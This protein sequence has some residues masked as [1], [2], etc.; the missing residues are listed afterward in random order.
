MS[1]TRPPTVAFQGE[2]G[3]FSDDAAEKLL[4]EATT[5]GFETFDEA[6]AAAAEG[7][8]DFALLPVENSITGAIP[9]TY[10]LLW[11][12][13][14]LRILDETIYRVEQ[15][16]IVLPG[17]SVDELHE[18]HSHP[19]ALEQC[20]I[21]LRAH[22]HLRTKVVGD[23]AGAVHAMVERGD[24]TIAAIASRLAAQRYGAEVLF[25]AIQDSSENFTRFLLVS[26]QGSARRNLGRACV[27]LTLAHQPGALRDALGVF[28]DAGM[29]IR[30]LV[31]RPTQD[32]AFVYRFYC[33]IEHVD[34]SKLDQA[35][36]KISGTSRILG[37]Y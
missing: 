25:P 8:V 30:S 33:E 36:S 31:S 17:V 1:I 28:A 14:N 13:S 21:F 35:L 15:N 29:N 5:R 18:V 23:T 22:P 12:H 24:R 10:D 9:R 20:R 19:V 26:R 11:I 4:P 3:A 2:P 6:S 7:S 37:F 16:L 32:A 34:Q 27:A